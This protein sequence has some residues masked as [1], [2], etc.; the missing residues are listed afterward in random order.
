MQRVWLALSLLALAACQSLP[1]TPL[2]NSPRTWP[3][4]EVSVAIVPSTLTPTPSLAPADIR[5]LG[6]GQHI[7][8]RGSYTDSETLAAGP[9]LC[10]IERGSPAFDH[11][12]R[13]P[14]NDILFSNS[15]PPPFTTE[16]EMMHTAAI[17]LLSQLEAQVRQEWGDAAQIMVTEAY[18]SR[19]THDLAQPNPALKY[20]L[21][22]E[23]RSLDVIP[24][25]PN[26]DRL[27]RLCALAHSAGFDWV[28][29]EGDHCHLSVMAESLCP[30]GSQAP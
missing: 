14:A 11:L 8:A 3:T 18:D 26:L 9:M 28:H 16:D 15:D 10:H 1:G 30:L 13:Y 2:A 6:T 27:A 22:F 29:N 19:L 12:A 23:G 7:S 24:W 5:T 20:S 4:A 21:H 25:P 17:G